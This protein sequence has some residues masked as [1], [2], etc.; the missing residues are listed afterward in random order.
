[1]TDQNEHTKQL[2]HE[3]KCLELNDGLVFCHECGFAAKVDVD[4]PLRYGW[5]M[6]CGKRMMLTRHSEKPE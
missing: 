6:H 3:R 2:M 4:Y 5:P 1:M